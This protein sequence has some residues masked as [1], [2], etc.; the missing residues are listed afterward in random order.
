MLEPDAFMAQNH[1]RGACAVRPTGTSPSLAAKSWGAVLPPITVR[2][3]W[4]TMGFETRTV[5]RLD[6]AVPTPQQITKDFRRLAKQSR[7]F[8]RL[9]SIN[10]IGSIE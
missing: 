4:R 1:P 6:R 9:E 8:M 3:H 10:V 7:E 5:S 2:V